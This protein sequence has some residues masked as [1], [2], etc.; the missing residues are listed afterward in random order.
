MIQVYTGNGKGKTTAAIGLA[1]RATGAGM[2]VYIGQ[3]IKKK[4]CSEISAL[5]KIKKIKIEQFGRGCFIKKNINQK[6]RQAAKEG[7][8]KVITVIKN[9]RYPVIILDEINVALNLG[10]IELEDLIGIIKGCP[11]TIE[12]IL[13]G[14]NAHPRIIQLSDLASEIK[15]VKHYFKRGTKARKGIEY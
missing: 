12:L 13:T 10:L 6:D 14:R 3:F 11:S 15:E 8:Q 2:N 9:K 1:I 4:H 5:S 7:I